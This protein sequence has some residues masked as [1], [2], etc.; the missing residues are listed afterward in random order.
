MMVHLFLYIANS[1]PALSQSS[2][3]CSKLDQ[4]EHLCI[5]HSDVFEA[6]DMPQEHTIKHH[7]DRFDPSAL[8]QISPLILYTKR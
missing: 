2:S 1:S 3:L 6:P 5:E 7:I 8:Y 4:W